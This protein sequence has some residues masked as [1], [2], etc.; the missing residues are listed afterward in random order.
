MQ[1]FGLAFGLVFVSSL[2][3]LMKKTLEKRDFKILE[4]PCKIKK[5][6]EIQDFIKTQWSG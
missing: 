2:L 1:Y 5:S 4:I 6:L 3:K